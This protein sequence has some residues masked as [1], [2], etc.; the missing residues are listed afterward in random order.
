MIRAFRIFQENNQINGRIVS[1]EE[2]DLSPGEV[3]IKVRYSGVNYKD[4]LA[5]SGKGRILKF[6]P[7]N[8]GIDAAG[9]V[10]SSGDSRFQPGEEVLVNGCGIGESVDGGYC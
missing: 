4:A 5:G 7:L 6:F 2:K 10:E 3:V 9:V 1:M 8:G